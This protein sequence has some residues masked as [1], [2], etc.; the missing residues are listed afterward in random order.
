MGI[1]TSTFKGCY[2]DQIRVHV[3]DFI[4]PRREEMFI[5]VTVAIAPDEFEIHNSGML[6]IPE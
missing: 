4:N 2:E 1:V 3:R 5:D 6:L